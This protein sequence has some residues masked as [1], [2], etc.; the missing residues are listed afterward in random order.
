MKRLGPTVLAVLLAAGSW[1]PKVQ[2]DPELLVA[3][4]F[5]SRDL[6]FPTLNDP[7]TNYTMVFHGTPAELEYDAGQGWGYE[8]VDPGNTDRGGYAIFGPF[9]D[10][11]NNRN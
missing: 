2:A 11:A 10:S 6:N 9:D 1:T 3:F 4:A 7:G 5:G 8:V